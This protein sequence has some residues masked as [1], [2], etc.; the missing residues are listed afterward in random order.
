MISKLCIQIIIILPK[1]AK[2]KLDRQHDYL[3][4]YLKGEAFFHPQQK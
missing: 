2:Q 1:Y 4:I 3:P